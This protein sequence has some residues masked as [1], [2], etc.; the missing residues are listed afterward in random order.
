MQATYD[1]IKA[2]DVS[3]RK[4]RREEKI[5]KNVQHEFRSR[6]RSDTYKEMNVSNNPEIAPRPSDVY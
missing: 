6:V 1:D 3:R 2:A 4:L 5:F